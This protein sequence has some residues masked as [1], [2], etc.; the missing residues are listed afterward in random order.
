MPAS[1]ECLQAFKKLAKSLK[2]RTTASLAAPP[3]LDYTR[4][5]LSLHGEHGHAV[6]MSWCM[7]AHHIEGHLLWNVEPCLLSHVPRTWRFIHL[8][9]VVPGVVIRSA[10]L[11][12]LVPNVR[13]VVP[14]LLP[15][16]YL[17]VLV[18]P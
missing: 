15:G 16:K 3:L 9:A 12:T 2:L 10:N 8:P 14:T 5:L 13:K 17:T 1:F 4:Q 18:V 7:H 11:T 6:G